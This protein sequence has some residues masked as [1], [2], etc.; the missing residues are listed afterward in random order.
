MVKQ[1]SILRYL[2][3]LNFVKMACFI[4]KTSL[5]LAN[6]SVAYRQ[7]VVDCSRTASRMSL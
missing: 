5:M 3:L 6:I 1:V 2:E 4:L 7:P